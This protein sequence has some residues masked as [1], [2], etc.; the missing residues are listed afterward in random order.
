MWGSP[1]IGLAVAGRASFFLFVRDM[2]KTGRGNAG[3]FGDKGWH[4]GIMAGFRG[5]RGFF[6]GS[7]QTMRSVCF[8]VAVFEEFIE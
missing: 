8:R 7:L 5:G 4:G 3:F 1:G 2:K 6:Y